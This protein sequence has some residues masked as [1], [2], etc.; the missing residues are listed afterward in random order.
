[1]QREYHRWHSPNLGRDMELLVFGH[2]G[3]R[4]LV[5]PTR[6]GRFYDY[7]NFGL[8]A[9]LADRIEQG[10]L[11]LFCVDSIDSE[12]IYNRYIGPS[13]RIRRHGQYEQ[14]ILN[15]VLPLSRLKNPQPFMI[16]HGCSLG[17]Y[18]ALNIAFRHP[19]WFGKV[20]ALSGRYD[21]S[22]PVAEFPSLFDT[23]YD[24]DIYF[25]TPNHFLPNLADG[26]VL[27]HLRR[28][29]IV[30]TIGAEDPFLGSNLALSEA[31]SAKQIPHELFV[32]SGRAHHPDDWHKMVQIY[33]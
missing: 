27:E 23:Y 16:S 11:Q 33:L 4:V 13:D 7:E 9:A 20:V 26:A 12:S 32:W 25:N 10:W 22:A 1:M 6:R 3:A 5:F 24:D 29:D 17:A 31:L 15:E 30:L 19:Q 2:A 8:V 14:Y 28:L 21:L 18:H